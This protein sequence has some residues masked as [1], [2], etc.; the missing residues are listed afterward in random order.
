MRLRTIRENQAIRDTP[1][2]VVAGFD[3]EMSDPD[4]EVD[5]DIPQNIDWDKITPDT[6]HKRQGAIVFLY[7][8]DGE[9][10][11][12]D[13]ELATH[14]DILFKKRRKFDIEPNEYFGIRDAVIAYRKNIAPKYHLLGR[15]GFVGD[16][17]VVAFWNDDRVSELLNPCLDALESEGII[18]PESIVLLSNGNKFQASARSETGN[19][20]GAATTVDPKKARERELMQQLHLMPP[21]QKKAAMKELGLVGGGHKQP[22]QKAAEQNKLVRPGQKWWAMQSESDS[23]A[24]RNNHRARG[25]N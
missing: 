15:C 20:S 8:D 19:A 18:T 3:S 12:D 25:R 10:F 2:R 24:N 9:L 17:Q 13:N 16:E 5:S 22:W 1:T 6:F 4:I 14:N 23:N 21:Q 11:Y 7:T